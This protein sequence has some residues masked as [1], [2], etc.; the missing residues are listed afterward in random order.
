MVNRN[1]YD[2]SGKEMSLA[3]R[4]DPDPAIKRAAA[5]HEGDDDATAGQFLE[6]VDAT[7]YRPADE[8]N[9]YN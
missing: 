3:T 9:F 2:W 1:E 5:A 8:L 6:R 7:R 4:E